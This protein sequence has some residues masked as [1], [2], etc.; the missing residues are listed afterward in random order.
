MRCIALLMA[1]YAVSSKVNSPKYN[2]EDLV[3][4]V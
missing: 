1:A 4:P 3:K 2:E